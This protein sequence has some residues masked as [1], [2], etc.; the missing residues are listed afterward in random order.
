[1]NVLSILIDPI[2]RDQ[3]QRSLPN[4]KALLDLFNFTSFSK[5]TAV[6]DNSGPNQAALFTGYP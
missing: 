1:M 5:Y 6:G 4:T 2:S 3:F